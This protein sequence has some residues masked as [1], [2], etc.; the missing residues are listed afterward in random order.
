MGAFGAVVVSAVD[1]KGL[2][3]TGPVVSGVLSGIAG[4]GPSASG[5]GSEDAAE[6]SCP[7]WF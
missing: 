4:V 3:D 1:F 2:A 7:A 5:A 6:P